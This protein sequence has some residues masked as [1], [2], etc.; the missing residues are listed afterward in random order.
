MTEE[1][2]ET[3]QA[4]KA[5][6]EHIFFQ[7]HIVGVQQA[8]GAQQSSEDVKAPVDGA[9]DHIS[10]PAA[11]S[12]AE[13]RAEKNEIAEGADGAAPGAADSGHASTANGNSAA[14]TSAA[15]MGGEPAQSVEELSQPVEAPAQPVEEPVL[16][17]EM[18]AWKLKMR[19]LVNGR[20]V[21]RPALRNEGDRWEVEYALTEL[22]PE[23]ANDLFSLLR[24]RR[25]GCFAKREGAA[26]RR[27]ARHFGAILRHYNLRGRE[28]GLARDLV[29]DR[30]GRHLFVP[31]GPGSDASQE[32][33]E[34]QESQKK[35]ES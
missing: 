12:G 7:R 33:Q 29:D 35:Q 23:Q 20:V 22:S 6:E 31:R 15:A 32:S 24:G 26:K 17:A 3:Q 25:I 10:E 19:N 8:D 14:A 16:P 9:V 5:E 13:S 34:S 21:K 2:I 18:T 11:G 4:K 27:F 30:L 28:A 1:A